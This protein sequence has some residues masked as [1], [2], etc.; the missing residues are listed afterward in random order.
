[1]NWPGGRICITIEYSHQAFF[2]VW[3]LGVNGILGYF[4]SFFTFF[5]FFFFFFR[6]CYAVYG[7]HIFFTLFGRME[8]EE[9]EARTGGDISMGPL[10]DLGAGREGAGEGISCQTK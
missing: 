2:W 7:Y 4:L 6:L 9:E 1:M 8:D 10:V 5:T 3:V